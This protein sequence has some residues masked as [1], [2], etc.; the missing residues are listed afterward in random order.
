M[1]M[2]KLFTP[3]DL[4]AIRED[5]IIA[6]ENGQSASLI[7][8]ILLPGDISQESPVIIYNF[9]DDAFSELDYSYSE[10]TPWGVTSD[11][12]DGDD[13]DTGY[14]L[15]TRVN[16]LAG[17]D[18]IIFGCHYKTDINIESAFDEE[19]ILALEEALKRIKD[20]LQGFRDERENG[21]CSY[22]FYTDLKPVN[23]QKAMESFS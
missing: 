15:I 23:V 5:A 14:M 19:T 11:Y 4:A 3:E 17:M 8:A 10:L 7:N 16:G 2:S 1:I 22:S 18:K 21:Q 9:A 13:E 20:G 6:Y 12:V